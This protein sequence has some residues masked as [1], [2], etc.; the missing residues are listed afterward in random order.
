MVKWRAEEINVGRQTENG[1]MIE[2]ELYD[3]VDSMSCGIN[4][5]Q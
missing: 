5:V 1:E 4:S 3:N 2:V